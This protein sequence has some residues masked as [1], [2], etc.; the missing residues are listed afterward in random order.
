MPDEFDRFKVNPSGGD[1]FDRFK[2]SVP[3]NAPSNA[4]PKSW[5]RET[6]ENFLQQGV[7]IAKSAGH[8]VENLAEIGHTLSGGGLIDWASKKLGGGEEVKAREAMQA[9]VHKALEPTNEA[10]KIGGV[11]GDL[12]QYF[13]PIGTGEIKA[14]ARAP[15]WIKTLVGAGREA[16]DMGLKTYAQTKDPMKALTSAGIAAPFGA[17]GGALSAGR[18]A[19]NLAPKESQAIAEV[20]ARGVPVSVGDVT[21]NKFVKATEQKLAYTP[22]AIGPMARHAA[23]RTEAGVRTLRTVPGSVGGRVASEVEAGTHVESAVRSKITDLKK[24]ANEA[25]DLTRTEAEKARKTVQIGTRTETSPILSPAGKPFET[26]KPILESHEFPVSMAPIRAAL[27]PYYTELAGRLPQTVREASPGFAALKRIVEGEE[28]MTD[29]LALDKDLSTVKGFLRRYGSGLKDQSGRYAAA[30]LNELEGGV[31]RAVG[32]GSPE[33]L[34]ALQKGRA[35]VRQY[36]AA[37]ELLSRLLPKNASPSVIYDRLT[38][39]SGRLLPDLKEL[40]RLAPGEVQTVGRTYLQG[41]ANDITANGRL[42]RLRLG[43]NSFRRLQPEVRDVLFGKAHSMKL[44]NLLQGLADIGADTNPSGT[45][46]WGAISEAIAVGT[47]IGEL[48]GRGMFQEAA[49]A[50]TLAGGQMIVANRLAHLLTSPAGVARLTQAVRL[51]PSSIGFRKALEAI[52][53]EAVKVEQEP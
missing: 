45:A 11:L 49:G 10:Q 31:T 22:G 26:T 17:A 1:E 53:V 38:Q 34:E 20:S 5:L 33:A 41:L 15:W 40:N 12:A 37:D 23:A 18:V 7:G 30:V 4:S 52:S 36:H 16:L 44:D 2:T 39:T 6:G 48:A 21:G 24:T 46:K 32:S 25:Y 42:E 13:I 8:T 51:S 27:T 3:S 28:S 9:Q 29:A 43:L 35:A 47:G 19:S 14:A 50:A